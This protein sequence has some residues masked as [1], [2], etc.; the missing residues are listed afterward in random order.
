VLG[1]LGVLDVALASS[2]ALY[3]TYPKIPRFTGVVFTA[4][5]R[6]KI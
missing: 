6:P 2:I 5:D 3:K 4:Q 1:V